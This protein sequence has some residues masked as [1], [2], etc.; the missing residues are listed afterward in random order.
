MTLMSVPIDSITE[1]HLRD[2]IEDQVMELRLIEYKRELPGR[3]DG[4]KKE[5]L[6]DVCSFANT[7]G[8]DLMYG[9]AESGGTPQHLV[10]IDAD[11]VDAEISRQASSIRDGIRPRIPGIQ[12]QP[13][14]L[15]NG[16]HALVLRIPRSFARPHVVTYQNH[17][18]FYARTSNGKYQM[19]VDEVRRAFVLSESVADRIRAFRAERLSRVVSGET[20]V[21]IE[22]TSRVVLHVVPISAFDA[23]ASFVDLDIRRP[24]LS[25]RALLPI[26]IVDEV[27]L[28]NPS[29]FLPRYNFDG[30]FCDSRLD[31]PGEDIEGY[32]QLFR[33]G[34]IEAVD[35]HTFLDGS[36]RGYELDERLVKA[37]GRYFQLLRELGVESPVFL[38]LSLVG[39]GD[40]QML[41]SGVPLHYRSAL[42]PVDRGDLLVPE[43]LVE[44][45]DQDVHAL[46]R[47]MRP[48]LDAVWNSVGAPR[49]PHYDE[50]G[51]W[52]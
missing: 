40:Y 3:S 42:R 32:A 45:L 15:E 50:S 20:P 26:S 47:H 10:G 16:E 41:Q 38:L 2:L 51:N 1:G 13:V 52:Q 22:G 39:V 6:S 29:A 12:H 31:L 24:P 37:V 49:S 5:F 4:E 28:S 11:N 33:T 25:D 9:I 14:R 43:V 17:W 21:P 46:Q 30:V 8:G 23:P 34:V 48:L 19:D 18:K 36:I 7:A 35:N 27:H 44:S